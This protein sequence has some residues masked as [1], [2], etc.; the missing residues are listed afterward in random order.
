[1]A[2]TNSPIGWNVKADQP[3][4]TEVQAAADLANPERKSYMALPTLIGAQAQHSIDN[5]N[6]ADQLGQQRMFAYHQVA[7]KIAENNAKNAIDV[8]RL[9]NDNPGA[10]GFAANNPATAGSFAGMDPNAAGPFNDWSSRMNTAKMVDLLGKGAQG[11]L[12]GGIQMPTDYFSKV[13][14]G[15]PALQY[16]DPPMVQAAKIKE[17]GSNARAAASGG[18]GGEITIHDANADIKFKRQSEKEA[19]DILQRYKDRKPG[20]G[21]GDGTQPGHVGGGDTSTQTR[22]AVPDLPMAQRDTPASAPSSAGVPLPNTEQ[23][24]SVRKQV[25][26][27][28]T[29]GASTASPEVRQK[30]ADIK[31][32]GN[33]DVRHDPKT[34]KIWVVGKTGQAYPV[35]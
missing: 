15:G 2:E 5:S 7:A 8:M 17:A 34:G 32:K 12:A 31:A 24:N 13:L 20:A 3:Y 18:G 6:Y 29:S 23:G 28:I 11:A 33:L 10:I 19:Y 9:G 16:G 22:G 35:N 14:P 25:S 26:D 21:G 4:A 1:M 27:A 30:I